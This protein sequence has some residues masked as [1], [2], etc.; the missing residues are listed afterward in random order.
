MKQEKKV[1]EA[2]KET[3]PVAKAAPVKIEVPKKVLKSKVYKLLGQYKNSPW[4]KLQSEDRPGNG[5]R[6]L[7]FDT[8]KGVK[9]AIRYV[10]NIDSPFIDKQLD[11]VNK[12]GELARSQVVF[13]G[14]VL[15][16]TEFETS[17]QNFLD[18]HPGNKRNGGTTFYEHD[19]EVIATQ[20]VQYLRLEAEAMKV[21]L[22]ADIQTAS[23]ILRPAHGVA[24][25][26]MKTDMITREL[27]LMAKKDP[28]GLLEVVASA[29]LMVKY[30]AFTSVDFGICTLTDGGLVYRWAANGE[31]LL[32]IGFGEDPY[33]A[34]AKFFTTDAGIEV[35]SRITNK[36]KK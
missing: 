8:E 22:D 29:D 24:I 21:A 11:Y 27:I 23:A 12:G 3:A 16:T 18:L 31:K 32:S 1:A 30:L 25:H 9:R 34:I 15:G 13:E 10:E 2:T 5:S 4:F 14:G 35:M 20:D 7:Y 17:L 36:L 33:Q 19:E 28:Q 26:E 6:L